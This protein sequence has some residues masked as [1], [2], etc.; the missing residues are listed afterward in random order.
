MDLDETT[1]RLLLG[2]LALVAAIGLLPAM[3]RVFRIHH[4]EVRHGGPDE[5]PPRH[6]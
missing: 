6:A 2:A 4:F 1:L 3:F 5:K